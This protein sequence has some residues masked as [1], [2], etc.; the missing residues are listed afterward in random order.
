MRLWS[1]HPCLLDHKG[2]VAVWREALL[3]QK[4]LQGKTVGYRSHPQL[5]RFRKCGQP[6]TAISTYLWAIHD[7]ATER[8]YA[9]NAGKIARNWKTI[10]IP[11]TQGQLL[12]E[13]AHL[14]R[15]LRVRDWR[16]F[17]KVVRQKIIPHPLFTVI[18][19]E[20]ESWEKV[21]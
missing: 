8:G 2:L 6:V 19:G 7:E 12:Y 10:T 3:A 5:Q 17:R 4:V 11:V 16:H 1:L 18:A 14:K 13:W 15:K 20:V 21:Q 9:F